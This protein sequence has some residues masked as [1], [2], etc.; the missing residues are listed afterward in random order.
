[1][2]KSLAERENSGTHASRYEEAEGR[3]LLEDEDVGRSEETGAFC[4]IKAIKPG[5]LS[6]AEG[7][8]WT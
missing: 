1:M 3:D 5:M 8:G 6:F 2:S 7:E 4:C